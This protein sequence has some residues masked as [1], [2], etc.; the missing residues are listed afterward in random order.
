MII[1]DFFT[2]PK[3]SARNVAENSQRVDSLVTDALRVMKGP[4][5]SD[6]VLALKRVLG[7]REYNSR[8]GFYSFYVDQIHRNWQ[9]PMYGQ[10]NLAEDAD[11]LPPGS[12]GS[13]PTTDYVKNLYSTAAER[14][15]AAPDPAAVKNSM[16]L[17]PK[18]DVDVS[19]TFNKGIKAF[20]NPE[21]T[22]NLNALTKLVGRAETDYINHPVATG[23]GNETPQMHTT[24]LT[25]KPNYLDSRPATGTGK[26]T[27]RLDTRPATARPNANYDNMMQPMEQ[28]GDVPTGRR[29]QSAPPIDNVTDID[30]PEQ[31]PEAAPVVPGQSTTKLADKD[32]SRE[33]WV[34]LMGYD[35]FDASRMAA[36][37]GP[38]AAANSV[39]ARKPDG[40]RLINANGLMAADDHAQYM[41]DLVAAAR[42]EKQQA[43]SVP[44]SNAV[45][46]TDKTE[47]V[48]MSMTMG[49]GAGDSGEITSGSKGRIDQATIDR[50]RA[51]AAKQNAPAAAP[52]SISAANSATASKTTAPSWQDIARANKLANPNLIYPGQLIKLPNGTFAEVDKGDTLSSIANRYRQGGY[53]KETDVG[54]TMDDGFKWGSATMPMQDGS[55]HKYNPQTNSYSQATPPTRP[56]LNTNIS[57]ITRDRTTDKNGQANQN[58]SDVSIATN[59]ATGTGDYMHRQD[60]NGTPTTTFRQ[61]VPAAELAKLRSQHFNE[62][63]NRM[64]NLA[65]I[66]K[67]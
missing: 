30:D 24:P 51:W 7:D 35:P 20:Q 32:R 39:P 62:D 1:N 31:E 19:G 33:D 23:T 21:L 65:G 17:N 36:A 48:R 66:R 26:E 50:A 47:P 25:Q 42:A 13:M 38:A 61:N 54:D 2:N 16:A 58:Y 67:K 3:R 46:S 34:K 14:G 44:A 52:K 63:I 12:L 10:Q 29:F 57:T 53:I 22:K 9:L 27:P 55:V 60:V 28:E 40:S 11:E 4:E 43:N 45:S 15:M 8:R 49:S 59:P 5:I 6:A 18:G 64:Q 41:K 56:D 37:A